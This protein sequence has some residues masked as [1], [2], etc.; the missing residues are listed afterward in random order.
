MNKSN[1]IKVVLL[2]DSGVGKT[3]ILHQLS[4]GK[5]SY[6]TQ[7][8]K[9]VDFLC[10]DIKLPELSY[11]ITLQIWDTAGQERYH[12][13][14]ATYYQQSA[15]AIVV[16][17]ITRKSSFISAKSWLKEM[18]EIG[19][20]DTKALLVGNKSDCIIKEEILFTEAKEY[21]DSV[22]MDLIIA[23]AKENINI[24][25]IFE[26][27]VKLV[28]YSE[29]DRRRTKLKRDIKSKTNSNCC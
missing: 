11:P 1:K 15:A 27:V 25:E 12:S 3:S 28:K 14:A 18:K 5:F 4:T 6:T 24:T 22:N 19:S 2:G 7:S 8:T 9:G 20:P 23:S 10:W 16:Y 26:H 29:I 17:D 13:M 21:A